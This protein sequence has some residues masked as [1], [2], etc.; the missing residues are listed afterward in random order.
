MNSELKAKKMDQFEDCHPTE[1]G[2]ETKEE[3]PVYGDVHTPEAI[4][5][6]R[7]ESP[8][9]MKPRAYNGTSSWREYKSHFERICRLNGWN[10]N[11]MDYLWVNLEGA[12]LSYVESLPQTRV[13]DYETVCE[14]LEERFG[15]SQLAE[16]FR[17]ELRGRRRKEGE[18]L[19]ALGQEIRRL[20]QYAYPGVGHDA[21]EEIALERYREALGDREQ[22]MSIRQGHSRTLEEAVKAATDMESWQ[23]SEG[24]SEVRNVRAVGT[25]VK[26]E[27]D[28]EQLKEM[29]KK[30][31]ESMNRPRK[32]YYRSPGS[33]TAC[34]RCGKDGHF[35]R[36]CR[37]GND[38]QLH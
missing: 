13:V 16:V 9:R 21:L 30:L 17:A 28:I 3:L 35:A 2:E 1:R 36:E 18:S 37:S 24:S 10:T 29:V 7:K 20:V 19:P 22:R 6:V 31:L 8:L 4:P 5:A 26:E 33:S 38:E 12:A 23:L 25:D 27:G 32:P 34:Y 11:R 15:E 14:S